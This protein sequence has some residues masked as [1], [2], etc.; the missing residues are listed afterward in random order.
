MNVITRTSLSLQFFLQAVLLTFLQFPDLNSSSRSTI[1]W[2]MPILN[3]FL[4][5]IVKL[6]CSALK[7]LLIHTRKGLRNNKQTW[8]TFHNA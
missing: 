8:L 7:I 1:A 3:N 2:N 4:I 5:P 6:S